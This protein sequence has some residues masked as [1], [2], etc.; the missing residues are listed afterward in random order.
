MTFHKTLWIVLVVLGIMMSGCTTT[1]PQTASVNIAVVA[2]NGGSVNGATVQLANSSHTYTRAIIGNS[3][4][5]TGVVLGTYTLTITHPD[6]ITFIDENFSVQEEGLINYTANFQ[7]DY[8]ASVVISFQTSNDAAITNATVRLIHSNEALSRTYERVNINGDGTLGNTAEVHFNEIL[9]GIYTLMIS[10]EGFRTFTNTN[11]HVRAQTVEPDPITVQ[12]VIPSE[13]ATVTIP[14]RTADDR[15]IFGAIVTITNNNGNP[16]LVYMQIVNSAQ[17]ASNAEVTFTDVEYG[18]Y[19]MTIE[20][21]GYFIFTNNNLPVQRP[22]VEIG[23]ISLQPSRQVGLDTTVT[24]SFETYNERPIVEAIVTLANNN[25]DMSLV[26]SRT[27]NG[28]G[29]GGYSA[30]VFFINEVIYGRY[31]LTI[32]L[33]G[34]QIYTRNSVEI[35]TQNVEIDEIVLLPNRAESVIIPFKLP[36]EQAIVGAVVTLVNN[37]NSDIVYTRT[38]NGEGAT[39]NAAEAHFVDEVVYGSYTLTITLNGYRTHTINNLVVNSHIHREPEITLAMNED[40]RVSV[41]FRMPDDRPRPF[42]TGFMGALVTLTNNNG[43]P[44]LVYERTVNGNHDEYAEALF[45]DEVVFGS[46]TLTIVLIEREREIRIEVEQDE[47]GDDVDVE[48]E[49]EVEIT[50]AYTSIFMVNQL[51]VEYHGIELQLIYRE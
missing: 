8:A 16:A 35:F 21:D 30:E 9:Y 19:T 3:V 13:I 40:M 26:Y 11:F 20:L 47:H 44:A 1:T 6:Y 36:N 39:G 5:I 51:D 34:Y 42:G 14:F 27:V 23:V 38:V 18:S 2:V 22:L 7:P 15:T 29:S 25:G 17:G 24:V 50:Y 49:V 4:N 33:D 12:S 43:N 28:E 46:Y 31:T 48:I 41:R 45:I 32:E 37:S 10:L